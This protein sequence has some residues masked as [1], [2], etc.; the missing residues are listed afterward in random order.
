MLVESSLGALEGEVVGGE[1]LKGLKQFDLNRSS[2]L[3]QPVNLFRP[4]ERGFEMQFF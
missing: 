1:L 3:P 2:F 4:N